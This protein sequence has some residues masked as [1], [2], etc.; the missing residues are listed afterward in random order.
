MLTRPGTPT[1]EPLREVQERHE[2]LFSQTQR[3]RG[4]PGVRRL[5]GLVREALHA[6][7]RAELDAGVNQ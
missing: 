6:R 2:R 5:R 4:Q 7:M 3:E 1:V